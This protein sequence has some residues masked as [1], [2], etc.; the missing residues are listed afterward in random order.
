VI[1]D[2]GLVVLHTTYLAPL[3]RLGAR[4]PALVDAYD[5]VWRAHVNDATYADPVRAAIRRG[6]AASV[7]PREERSLAR[8]AQVLVAGAD[9]RAVIATRLPHARWVGTPTPV[10]PVPA[11]PARDQLRVG[12]I[13]N[14]AHVST[15]HSLELLLASPLGGDPAVRIVVVGL[16]SDE[17]VT[18]SANLD[19]LGQLARAEDFYAQVDCVVAPV[20]GGSG[21]K[22]KLGEAILAGRPVITTELGAAGYPRELHARFEICE[23]RDLT[24]ARVRAAIERFDPQPARREFDQLLGASAVGD[25]YEAALR[26]ALE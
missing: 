19:V 23:P 17:V 3:A 2:A 14:F 5:L 10:E 1:D 4:A 6:Y 21:I 12:L 16:H 25:A 15:R 24:A 8:T 13:G 18:A 11:P 26:Q 22:C 20:A 9:D 7:R